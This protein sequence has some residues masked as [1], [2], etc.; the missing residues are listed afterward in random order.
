MKG[1]R[2]YTEVSASNWRIANCA[3]LHEL[4]A[5]V[6][7]GLK[8]GMPS[9]INLG[10]EDH[11]VVVYG[12]QLDKAGDIQ[13][14]HM[15]DPMP[16][17]TD[18][19]KH[20]YIDQCSDTGN[21]TTFDAPWPLDVP[22]LRRYH[23]AIGRTPSPRGMADY[24]GRFVGIVHGTAPK[25]SAVHALLKKFKRPRRSKAKRPSSAAATDFRT[26]LGELKE[27]AQEWNVSALPE[28]LGQNEPPIVRLVEDIGGAFRPYL[29]LSMFSTKLKTGM[30][31]VFRSDGALQRLQFF[32][33]PEVHT[34]LRKH[35]D[36]TL[37]WTRERLRS[38]PSPIFPFA[39]VN[40]TQ[41]RYKRLYDGFAFKAATP[42][43]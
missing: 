21:P 31:A 38:L 5:E 40:G 37:W 10:S 9:I 8:K 19:E 4:L 22:N 36:E 1:A 14:L 11:W 15:R 25:P 28:L 20:T 29:L 12:A 39:R 26:L 13:V 6:V 35:P 27:K 3:T 16:Q 42:P 17:L 2:E 24:R 43:H 41:N 32:N 30:V 23:L 18:S 34:S 7:H 33:G